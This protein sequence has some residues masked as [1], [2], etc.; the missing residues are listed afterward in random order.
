VNGDLQFWRD[1]AGSFFCNEFCADD[2][3]EVR[4]YSYRKSYRNAKELHAFSGA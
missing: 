1:A 3:E 4:F 2:A